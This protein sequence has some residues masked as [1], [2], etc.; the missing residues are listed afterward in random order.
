MSLKY[1]P[2]FR[3]Y[4]YPG[5]RVLWTG[6]PADSHRPTRF[7]RIL[8]WAARISFLSL[9]I[10][11]PFLL[12]HQAVR[13]F[14]R[15]LFGGDLQAGDLG[16]FVL[17][18]FSLKLFYVL[19]AA[20]LLTLVL[21]YLKNSA[22]FSD[23]GQFYA[24]TPERLLI[25]DRRRKNRFSDYGRGDIFPPHNIEYG[26]P[27]GD[28]IFAEEIPYYFPKRQPVAS[29]R[30]VGF[31]AIPDAEKVFKEILDWSQDN[32]GNQLIEN[33]EY[34]FSLSIPRGW[35][36]K[37]IFVK[38]E[39]QD[40]F[41]VSVLAARVLQLNWI[42]TLPTVNLH[43][44]QRHWHWNTL[45]L[46]QRR[47]TTVGFD[48]VRALFNTILVEVIS[49]D[50]AGQGYLYTRFNPHFELDSLLLEK[51]N[52]TR[53]VQEALLICSFE[54]IRKTGLPRL[55]V[56]AREIPSEPLIGYQ[57]RYDYKFM[58]MD[59]VMKQVYRNID[60]THF[61]FTIHWPGIF[62]KLQDDFFMKLVSSLQTTSVV[63]PEAAA[64]AVA[65]GP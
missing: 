10:L 17:M 22:R 42:N 6:V 48:S 46:T 24:R 14:L 56:M 32:Q 61:R 12:G 60:Q 9:F 38:P 53:V 47:E 37:R 5:E 49:S 23:A 18:L 39:V 44:W 58:G 4:L 25:L 8:G 30:K 55:H 62:D 15:K 21:L 26:G 11:T 43:W 52:L 19:L 63:T 3:K 54:S 16:E 1:Q 50:K 41:L 34:R 65:A 20:L 35:S 51:E 2:V 13:P 36:A 29:L 40:N 31:F 28:V 7:I 59:F 64:E 57:M 27:R 45:I 33:E